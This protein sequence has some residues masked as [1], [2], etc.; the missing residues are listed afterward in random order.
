MRRNRFSILLVSVCIALAGGTAFAK[1][2]P[3][4]VKQEEGFYYGYG[5]GTTAEEASLEAKRDLVSSALTATLR[6]VDAKASRVSASDKSVEARL[7]D[8]KP[9]V[10]A[11]KGSSPAVTYRIKIADWD[12]KEKAYADTL[13]ADLAARFN[14][15]ANKSDVSG[16]INESLAIL[17]ALSDAGETELLTAQPAGTELLSR[18]VEAVCADAGRTLVFTIS[19]KDGFIDPASQFSVNAADSSGNAVA[20]LTLAVTWET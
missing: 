4:L 18:K 12:K 5:K 10:E 19:V 6:A 7:G 1:T 20:G 17:A 3:E 11:K 13:R 8:L 14:G 15:L 9:Y 16:R 2:S